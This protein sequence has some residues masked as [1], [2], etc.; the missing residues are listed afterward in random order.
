MNR[1]LDSGPLGHDR[2]QRLGH[3]AGGGCG[4]SGARTLQADAIDDVG[5]AGVQFY[6]DGNPQGPEDTIAPMRPTGTPG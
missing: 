4:L 6:V 3:L 5:V 2:T 1:P